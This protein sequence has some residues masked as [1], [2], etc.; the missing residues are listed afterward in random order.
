M[1]WCIVQMQAEG[2]GK[3]PPPL[4]ATSYLAGQGPV[5]RQ[6]H[7]S[8]WSKSLFAS[9]FARPSE[10]SNVGL[11]MG[12]ALGDDEGLRRVG[13]L[14]TTQIF[15]SWDTDVR[16]PRSTLSALNSPRRE[17]NANRAATYLEVEQKR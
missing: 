3:R 11:N 8:A 6:A 15:M 7:G 16:F 2:K 17:R 4:T 9:P 14:G 12:W 5:D 13:P 10:I 1:V